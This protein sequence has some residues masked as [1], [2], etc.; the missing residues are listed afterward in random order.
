[1][2]FY[3]GEQGA[4]DLFS[5]G[6]FV[7]NHPVAG[8]TPFQSQVEMATGIHVEARPVPR[9]LPQSKRTF[10]YHEL[11]NVFPTK[12]V[13]GQNGIPKVV[14]HGIFCFFQGHGNAPLGVLGIGFGFV[15]LG[16]NGNFRVGSGLR[17]F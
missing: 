10:R 1:M 3:P 16:E 9:Q 5:R 7:V 11:H 12:P 6:V 2:G 13:S 17:N 4:D 15:R 14:L 8:V